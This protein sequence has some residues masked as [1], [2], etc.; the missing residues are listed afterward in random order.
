MNQPSEERLPETAE[1]KSSARILPFER[2]PTELQRAMQARAQEALDLQ[3]ERA[4]TK[5]APLKWTV[6]FLLALIPVLLLVAGIDAF[7]RV[8]HHINDT[9]S[10]MPVPEQAQQAP[11]VDEP[12]A[13]QQPGVVIL[14]SV[15]Q[16][17]VPEGAEQREQEAA[18]Q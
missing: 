1:Q 15:P 11:S 3:R 7:V 17:P 18:A 13:P 8:F 2:P 6:M 9:Y 10:K 12:R 14:E 5:P 4:K 16:E